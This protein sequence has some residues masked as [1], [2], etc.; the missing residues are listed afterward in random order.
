MKIQEPPFA[1]EEKE[2]K[3]GDA[4]I[5]MS[6]TQLIVEPAR[7][8]AKE[9]AI[10]EP[11][12]EEKK[13]DGVS[14]LVLVRDGKSAIF[15]QMYKN[16]KDSIQEG[17]EDEKD[18]EWVVPRAEEQNW[19]KF[20]RVVMHN[21]VKKG[22][23]TN[24]LAIKFLIAHMIEELTFDEQIILLNEF[25]GS[26]DGSGAV[27]NS[28]EKGIQE[29]FSDKMLSL[30]NKKAILLYNEKLNQ[31]PKKSNR[32]SELID[33]LENRG[34]FLWILNDDG[35]WKTGKYS[36]YTPYNNKILELKKDVLNKPANNIIG[37]MSVFKDTGSTVF[38]TKDMD[39]ARNTGARCDQSSKKVTINQI[40]SLVSE[41]NKEGS[42]MPKKLEPITDKK[43]TPEL[44][45]IQEFYL[46]L[47]DHLNVNNKK[48]FFT[49]VELSLKSI[50]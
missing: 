38:K 16:Y 13:S 20:C 4:G 36:D 35:K 17:S 34:V 22:I 33:E 43:S 28:L 50:E 37:F 9:S 15:Q 24:V 32:P 12:V 29:Y 31:K 21:M 19:F 49:Q 26:A 40:N 25:S 10:A 30:N 44:C 7:Q 6:K 23:M 18:G 1:Y 41:A 2:Q 11:L 3:N 47:F 48:W 14:D 27:E 8:L 39:K 46:R 42:N 5:G 45:V